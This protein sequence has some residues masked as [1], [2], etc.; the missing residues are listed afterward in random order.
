MKRIDL[1]NKAKELGLQS[2]SLVQSLIDWIGLSEGPDHN[3]DLPDLKQTV[4][5]FVSRLRNKFKKYARTYSRLI[6]KERD[7]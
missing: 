1:A 2:D 6:T 7:W 5:T 3:I 4:K